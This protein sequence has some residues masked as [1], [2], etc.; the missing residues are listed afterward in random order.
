VL[1]RTGSTALC[2]L[3]ES[4]R[5]LGHPLEYLNPTALPRIATR[6]AARDVAEYLD[7]LRRERATRNGVFGLKASYPH[8]APLAKPGVISSLLGDVRFV[9]LIREDMV[10]QAI[11]ACIAQRSGV[12]HRDQDGK[13]FRSGPDVEDGDVEVR[14]RMVVKKLDQLA[15]MQAEWERFF[16]LYSVQPLRISYEEFCDDPADAVGRIADHVGVEWHGS[17]SMDAAKTSKLADER[18]ARLAAKVRRKYR[19]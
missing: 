7:V 9:Y 1:P 10:A 17:V 16:S 3:L 2:S 6:F 12:W 19:L 8:L 5:V 15:E 11:S 18:N 14:P 13:P 4:T